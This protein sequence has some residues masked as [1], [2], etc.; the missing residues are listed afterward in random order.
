MLPL[1]G[2]CLAPPQPGALWQA[3]LRIQALVHPERCPSTA[4]LDGSQPPIQ[5]YRG[6]VA[7][8]RGSDSDTAVLLFT[9]AGAY[10]RFDAQ[11]VADPSARQAGTL[12]RLVALQ[13]L[14]EPQRLMLSE[15]VDAALTE[16]DA[17]ADLCAAIARIGPPRYQPD[18]MLNHGEQGL[19]RSLPAARSS[20]RQ[21]P[22]GLVQ[23]FTAEPAWNQ[24]LDGLL[25]CR[26]A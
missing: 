3:A 6:V 1:M 18:Y 17:N 14:S 5:L 23:G 4:S 11:R 22:G 10:V 2:G 15:G 21:A 8:L 24:V 19:R 16:P 20:L 25:R 9:L 12:L 13:Q 7:C 26:R